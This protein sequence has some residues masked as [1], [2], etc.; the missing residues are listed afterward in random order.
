MKS[1]S[2]IICRLLILCLCCEIEVAFPQ[3]DFWARADAPTVEIAVALA[4]NTNGDIFAA[5]LGGGLYRSIDN[6]ENWLPIDLG[7]IPPGQARSVVGLVANSKGDLFANTLTG[8]FRTG[9]VGGISRSTDS[10]ETWTSFATPS[11][12]SIVFNANDHIF[13]TTFDAGIFRSMDN[14][15][16]WEPI[17]NGLVSPAVNAIAINPSGEIF[18]AIGLGIFLSLDNGDSWTPVNTSLVS[19]SS[20]AINSSGHLF[21]GSYKVSF[22][23]QTMAKTGRSSMPCQ[24]IPSHRLLVLIR[25]GLFSSA[26]LII[27]FP[28]L[29]ASTD[30]QIMAIIGLHATSV[31]PLACQRFILLSLIRPEMFSPEQMTASSAP[32]IMAIRGCDAL[33]II[34]PLQAPETFPGLPSI[35]PATSF[36][37]LIA[38]TGQPTM[39]AIGQF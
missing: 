33:P 34:M 35:Q 12:N 32:L 8:S 3:T 11:F 5:T 21:G 14:G 28:A 25:M 22:A 2:S 38:F 30:Q 26:R 31:C 1:P 39:A 23:P 10:G 29:A 24:V 36:V 4:F 16:H 20:L 19:I 6:G 7:P 15:D 9:Y 13:A 27:I 37:E 17:S 18:V